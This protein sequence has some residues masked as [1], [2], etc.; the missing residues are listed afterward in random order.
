MQFCFYPILENSC[1]NV[2]HCPHLGG[3]P[4]TELVQIAN[5]SGQTG[6]QLQLQLDA[7]R[8]RSHKFVGENQRLEKELEQT[9]LKLKLKRQN[10]SL[11]ASKKVL[12][13]LGFAMGLVSPIAKSRK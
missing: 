8:E 2:R 1:G 9:K 7:E 5:D 12:S 10:K 4:I 3:A 6:Q 13:Q 11:P